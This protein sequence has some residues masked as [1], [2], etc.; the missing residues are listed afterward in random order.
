MKHK[1]LI[2]VTRFI[3]PFIIAFCFYIQINGSNAPGGGFQ[4][5]VIMASA[6]ILCVIIFGHKII[7]KVISF[8]L[9]K[10]LS[11]LGILIYGFTGAFC[12]ITG[13]EF[14]NYNALDNQFIKGQILGISLIEWGVAITVFATFSLAYLSFTT[15]GQNEHNVD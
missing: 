9:L 12:M 15:R 10:C 11:S 7:M 13:K 4:S 1:L 6:F 3:L 5:G 14:L 2:T 8:N